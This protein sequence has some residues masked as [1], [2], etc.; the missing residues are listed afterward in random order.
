MKL[1]I[2]SYP[3][4]NNSPKL[5]I[6]NST[7]TSFP[8]KGFLSNF[9]KDALYTFM[10]SGYFYTWLTIASNFT[11]FFSNL[12]KLSSKLVYKFK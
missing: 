2:S 5:E 4:F 6:L 12:V 9:L 11:I 10:N 7:S 3:A 8:F 1:F